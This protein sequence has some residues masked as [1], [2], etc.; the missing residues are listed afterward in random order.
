MH[1]L[2]IWAAGC[3]LLVAVLLGSA[4]AVSWKLSKSISSELPTWIGYPPDEPDCTK[5]GIC[6]SYNFSLP[7]ATLWYWCN[8]WSTKHRTQYWFNATG[9]NVTTLLMRERDLRGCA[10]RNLTN[11][12]ACQQVDL[13]MVDTKTSGYLRIFGMSFV[14]PACFLVA[15]NEKSKNATVSIQMWQ[16]FDSRRYY[17]TVFSVLFAVLLI[18]AT[19]ANTGYTCWYHITKSNHNHELHKP[20]PVAT[21]SP[22]DTASV[23]DTDSQAT[24]M[25]PTYKGSVSARSAQHSP[26]ESV[27]GQAGAGGSGGP[28]MRRSTSGGLISKLKALVSSDNKGGHQQ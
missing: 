11:I 6:T 9:A 21:P 19:L 22:M 24:G 23:T 10:L 13:S 16:Y 7:A 26:S 12:K 8:G 4:S 20:A 25:P 28:Q 27:H 15:N 2:Q 3:T 14:D 17:G 18:C 1:S 5:L